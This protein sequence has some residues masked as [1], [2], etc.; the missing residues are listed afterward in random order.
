MHSLCHFRNYTHMRQTL[1]SLSKSDDEED[2]K[3]LQAVY[4]IAFFGVPHDGMD[5]QSLISIVG[6]GPNRFLLE[7]IGSYGSQILG[8]YNRDF[9]HSLGGQ[10][11]S[12]IICFYETLL[13][14]TATLV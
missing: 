8:I 13:S 12:K 9:P 10:G 3:L 1:I 5:I 7:S 11:E 4:G 2:Q 6:N 14:P